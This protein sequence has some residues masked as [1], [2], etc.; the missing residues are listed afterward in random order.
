MSK[1]LFIKLLIKSAFFTIG[2]LLLWIG[3]NTFLSPHIW[4]GMTISKSALTV[5]YCE[6]NDITQFFHQRI[7]T[8][9]N[10]SYFFFGVLIIQIALEDYKNQNKKS[11]NR[12]EQFPLLSVL[13]GFYFIYLSFGSAFFHA[14]LTYIGQRVDMNGTYGVSITLLSIGVY[15]VFHK[16]HLSDTAKYIWIGALVVFIFAFFKIALLVSSSILLPAMI[17]SLTIMNA[18]NYFQFRKERSI[19]LAFLGFA[20]IIIAIKIRTLDVQKVSCDPHSW[21]QGH[22][23]WHFLTALSSFCSYAFFRFEN[24]LPN[25]KLE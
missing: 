23:L 11:L 5:E 16:I 1:H 21:Y 7:N 12:M 15:H 2:M 18:I 8:Y 6:F 14:S 10:L 25:Q 24:F 9:S 17:L 4:D 13:M 20:L 19:L 3:I 22:A